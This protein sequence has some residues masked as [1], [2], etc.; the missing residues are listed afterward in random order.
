V[1]RRP[2]GNVVS[3]LP[4]SLLDRGRDLIDRGVDRAPDRLVPAGRAASRG[5][6]ALAGVVERIPVARTGDRAPTSR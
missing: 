3:G 2:P 1:S 4:L 5:L 6:A